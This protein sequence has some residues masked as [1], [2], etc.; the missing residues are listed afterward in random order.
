MSLETAF[1]PSLFSSVGAPAASSASSASSNIVTVAHNI[2][3][4]Q[5]GEVAAADPIPRTGAAATSIRT[6]LLTVSLEREHSPLHIFEMMFPR[7]LLI[8]MLQATN[9]QPEMLAKPMSKTI[10]MRFLGILLT[11]TLCP[12]GSRRDMW[13]TDSRS[14]PIPPVNIGRFGLS[15]TDFERYLRNLRLG[16]L[17]EDALRRDPWAAVRP[18]IDHFNQVRERIVYPD[19]GDV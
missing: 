14:S 19:L 5:D 6:H 9:Q 16:Q 7:E 15:R 18:A 8:E 4:A 3:W 12:A 11:T 1:P 17:D 2:S 13:G 10:L